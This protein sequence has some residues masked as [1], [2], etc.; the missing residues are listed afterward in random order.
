[1]S[2]DVCMCVAGDGHGGG[3]GGGG[4]GVSLLIDPLSPF[5]VTLHLLLRLLLDLM[6]HNS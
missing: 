4:G 2:S 3:G 5:G 1:M 6:R